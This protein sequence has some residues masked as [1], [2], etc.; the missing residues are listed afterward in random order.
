[1][2]WHFYVEEGPAVSER[3]GVIRS[4]VSHP[5]ETIVMQAAPFEQIHGIILGINIGIE[6]SCSCFRNSHNP[7]NFL[8]LVEEI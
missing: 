5:W 2:H 1:M 7:N 6:N 8:Q 4:T 3:I